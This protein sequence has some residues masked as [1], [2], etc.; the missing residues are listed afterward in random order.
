MTGLAKS[1]TWLGVGQGAKIGC[2]LL[3][4]LILSRLLPPSA[5]GV[6]AM[7]AVVMAFL[8]LLRDLGTGAAIIQRQDLPES[9]A[10][11][12]FW[13]NLGVGSLLGLCLVLI[14]SALASFFEEPALASV[15]I[16]LAPT[17]PCAG[18]AASHMAMM[19]RSARF[20]ELA[21]IEVATQLIALTSTVLL[22][23]AGIGVESFAYG[24]LLSG[25]LSMVWIWQQ[26]GWTPR[27]VWHTDQL[28]G[29]WSMSANLTGFN[30]VNYFARNADSMIVGKVLGAAA[31]GQYNMAYKLMLFPVQN[32]SWVVGRALLPALSRLQDKPTELAATYR[33]VLGGIA[34]LSA[35]LMS[36]MWV[37]REE[38]ASTVLGPTWSLVGGLLF[39]LAPV[40]LLQS[41]M[42]TI[43]SVL[44][45][46][47]K[48]DK[49]FHL[50]IFN[51][52]TVV[53]GFCIGATQGV[54]AVAAAY[55]LANLVNFIVTF[56]CLTRWL[57]TG[58]LFH[59]CRAPLLSAAV[60]TIGVILSIHAFNSVAIHPLIR[61]AALISIGAC[62]YLS[63]LRILLGRSLID[64]VRNTWH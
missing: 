37:L 21:V 26:S 54:E 11:T 57:G 15:L 50:G 4:L 12:I 64:I 63:M 18:I 42:S 29:I 33:R 22:A 20:K 36:G 17:F 45:S 44:T 1:I 2:Q 6:L 53:V 61:L 43:G 27:R 47:G 40:G 13:F 39:W 51:T 5:H 31:L 30:I 7:A 55:F 8:G 41:F 59:K 48:A 56:L 46:Q 3:S 9:L 28:L 60:M 62:I 49:L 52:L 24:T 10:S 58:E 19:E 16:L 14:S 38:L 23:I 25:G 34:I 35:P 32:M